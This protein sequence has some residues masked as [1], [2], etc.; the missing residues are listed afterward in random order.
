[1]NTPSRSSPRYIRTFSEIGL[2]DV[3]LVGGKNAS[4]GEMFSRLTPLGV[5]VPDGYAIT[6]EA[7]RHV[8]DSAALWPALRAALEGLIPTDL[9]DLAARAARL[10]E[11]VYQAPLP[12]DLTQEVLTAYRR[13]SGEQPA[14]VAVRSSATAEDLPQ[15]SFAGQHESYLN[16]Q[17]E[18]ALLD[19]CKRCFASLFTDWRLI[20]FG[21]LH[22]AVP[23]GT[24]FVTG[25]SLSEVVGAVRA[26]SAS[27]TAQDGGFAPSIRVA[28][29]YSCV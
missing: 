21:R 16:I 13:L 20:T 8:L 7:Y 5:R 6:A 27:V 19:A 4:L 24:P 28:L 2:A 18:A 14:S 22:L 15:A 1:M 23:R 17:G 26:V 10:R 29:L 12:E 9:A 3:P 11:L 25:E